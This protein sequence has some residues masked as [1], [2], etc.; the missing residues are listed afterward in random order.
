MSKPAPHGTPKTPRTSNR[1]RFDLESTP[2][3]ELKSWEDGADRVA[4]GGRADSTMSLV[5]PSQWREHR[6]NSP[7]KSSPQG[8]WLRGFVFGR[9]NDGESGSRPSSANGHASGAEQWVE[10]EDPLNSDDYDN[11]GSDRRESLQRERL[12]EGM[13]AGPVRAALDDEEGRG[14][15]AIMRPGARKGMGSAFMNMANSIIG[16]GIIGQPYALR[17]AGLVTGVVLL[18][19]LTFVVCVLFGTRSCS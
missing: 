18:I 16:A 13:E 12:L 9:G 14:I 17:Q 5:S 10:E 7:G 2:T 8:G 1:V 11:G 15:E 6:R 19:G 4:R 3:I